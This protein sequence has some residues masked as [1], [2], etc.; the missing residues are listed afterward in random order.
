MFLRSYYN[1][2]N[3]Y[4][5]KIYKIKRDIAI[6]NMEGSFRKVII[7]KTYHNGNDMSSFNVNH[8]SY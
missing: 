8:I 7:N 3:C 5:S 4:K 2:I 1:G 6:L